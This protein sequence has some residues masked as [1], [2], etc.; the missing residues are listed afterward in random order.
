VFLRKVCAKPAWLF[1]WLGKEFT[2][3]PYFE[4]KNL[5]CEAPL[6]HAVPVGLSFPLLM[7]AAFGALLIQHK[8]EIFYQHYFGKSVLGWVTSSVKAP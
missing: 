2:I 5:I 8:E 4:S 3:F 7:A 1:S 6:P